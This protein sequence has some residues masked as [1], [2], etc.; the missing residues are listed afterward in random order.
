MIY[1]D[2]GY[3]ENLITLLKNYRKF[4]YRNFLIQSERRRK[5]N[6][7]LNVLEKLVYLK[8]GDPKIDIAKLNIDIAKLKNYNYHA[9]LLNKVQ[10]LNINSHLQN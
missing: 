2:L 5:L 6:K 10:T 7:F 3:F 9:W 8:E 4:L 1:Y